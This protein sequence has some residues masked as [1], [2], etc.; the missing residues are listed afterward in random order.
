MK[1]CTGCKKTKSVSE[2]HKNKSK[3][4]GLHCWC[5]VCAGKAMKKYRQ[6]ER[7]KIVSRR[8]VKKYCR[9]EK[10]KIVGRRAKLK[11]AFGI[12]I[13]NYNWLFQ[14]QNGCCAICEKHQSELKH[15]LA[16]DH[17]HKTGKVRGLLCTKCN[18][19]LSLIEN[20]KRLKRA[21]KYIEIAEGV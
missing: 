20:K 9:T 7:G 1:F 13:K 6:T 5:K 8:S 2:F 16:V 12:T 11:Q 15:R 21:I 14:N 3:K 19:Q 18:V 17:N 4:D 10:G